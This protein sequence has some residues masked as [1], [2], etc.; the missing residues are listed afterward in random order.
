MV[1][2]LMCVLAYSTYAAG[3][4]AISLE[5]G[6][7]Y[8][9]KYSNMTNQ[10]VQ[11]PEG[12]EVAIAD[13]AGLDPNNPLTLP[14]QALLK[15]E[16]LRNTSE[17][18]LVKHAMV[19]IVRC[20][21]F[22]E[23]GCP[24]LARV[25]AN[26]IKTLLRKQPETDGDGEEDPSMYGYAT[27]PPP[28]APGGLSTMYIFPNILNIASM[29]E[30]HELQYA[31]QQMRLTRA[32]VDEGAGGSATVL[33]PL[34]NELTM[35]TRRVQSERKRLLQDTEGRPGV[36]L[37][38]FVTIATVGDVLQSVYDVDG[39][40]Y[41]EVQAKVT[42]DADGN[43]GSDANFVIEEVAF[44]RMASGCAESQSIDSDMLL[45]WAGRVYYEAQVLYL[46]SFF[47]AAQLKYFATVLL[48]NVW[49][50]KFHT[51]G[52]DRA[53]VTTLSNWYH[54]SLLNISTCI[55]HRNQVQY[56]PVGSDTYSRVAE[57]AQ[58]VPL[59]GGSCF[60]LL[61]VRHLTGLSALNLVDWCLQYHPSPHPTHTL[62][63]KWRRALVLEALWKFGDARV[64]VQ[65]CLDLVEEEVGGS[66]GVSRG[67]GVAS[68]R[69]GFMFTQEHL[70]DPLMSGPARDFANFAGFQ[71]PGFES[72]GD[73]VGKSK[74]SLQLQVGL[75]SKLNRLD[76]L[77]KTN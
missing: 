71:L 59:G 24:Y 42:Q 34:C 26:C 69:Y 17:G 56:S 15:K 19:W 52:T 77:M 31:A 43:G 68:T 38:E 8:L 7:F 12:A 53:L 5:V 49:M 47:L 13:A 36:E 40:L 66:C 2:Q 76:Y 55:F 25:H 48:V 63:T 27:Q 33:A 37:G 32:H 30:Q 54:C 21:G 28:Q 9:K 65:G 60:V 10:R 18:M 35:L 3:E 51:L 50:R 44:A 11:A 39:S 64:E 58:S 6:R 67:Q 29:L 70:V 14:M 72:D 74:A 46:E 22:L 73:S 45:A 23:I 75:Q 57:L 41:A 16:V 20:L 4:T 62:A 1:S 61:P